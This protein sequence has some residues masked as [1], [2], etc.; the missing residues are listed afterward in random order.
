MFKNKKQG[1]ET[2]DITVKFRIF[3]NNE[4]SELMKSVSLEYI[5]TVNSIVSNMV[6][7]QNILKLSSKDIASIMPSAV[8]NQAIRDAKSIYTK[9]KQSVRINS[10]KHEDK[11]KPITVPVLKKPVCIWN[12][13]NYSVKEGLL[14]FPIMINDKSHRISVKTLTTDY[15]LQYLDYKLGS[16]RIVRKSNKW[17]AQIS[18]NHR[19]TKSQGTNV[20]G[21]DLGLKVPAVAVTQC[22][23]TK[24]L[25]NGRQN[26]Y[27][28][29]IHS[30]PSEAW[31]LL[32]G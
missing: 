10:K 15:Q 3:P 19:E 30:A 17:I 31:H 20:M 26:K 6:S 23:K 22:G 16:L 13:Q 5:A 29:R 1:G 28:K 8:K 7:A 2:L 24:F 21:V 32:V 9:Y 12:N 25:G 11:Q 4:Q 14:S 27:I 18:V